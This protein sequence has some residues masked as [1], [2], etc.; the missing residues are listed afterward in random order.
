M[1]P[2]SSGMSERAGEG[3][4]RVAGVPLGAV[5]PRAAA[6]CSHQVRGHAGEVRQDPVLDLLFQ[7]LAELEGERGNDMVLLGGAH[8]LPEHRGLS[9]VIGKRLRPNAASRT[10]HDRGTCT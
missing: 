10:G 5:L 3:S 1:G 6:T 7:T 9:V 4:K 8:A 2:G